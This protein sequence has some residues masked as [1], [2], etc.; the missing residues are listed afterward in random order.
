M[1]GEM[2]LT[3]MD[4]EMGFGNEWWKGTLKIY[5]EWDHWTT[6]YE[7]KFNLIINF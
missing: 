1:T 5:D 2:G 3:E 7:S 6:P 4:G